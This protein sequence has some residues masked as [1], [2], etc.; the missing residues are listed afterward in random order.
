MKY[1][2]KHTTHYQYNNQVSMCFNEARMSPL[3][4]AHQTCAR[5][6]FVIH[7]A[8]DSLNK[9]FDYFGNQVTSFDILQPHREMSVT[10]YSE[11]QVLDHSQQA[12]FVGNEP[13]E[14]VRDTLA[15]TTNPDYLMA[16]EYMM[17]SMLIPV[18]DEV[19]E[20]ALASFTPQRP[21]MDAVRDLMERIFTD[22][23]YDPGFSTIS[24]PLKTVLAHRRGVC[25]DFAHL[26]IACVRS[27][28]L[29]AGYVS[30]Y[31]ETL[32]PPGEKKME[33]ADASHAWFS[34]YM[35][36]HGWVQF[37]PTNNIL[38]SVQHITLAF[39]R[40]FAD[41]TPLKGVIYGGDDHELSV[42]VDVHRIEE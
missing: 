14:S 10:V 40:D 23:K 25:Q 13:W 42:F 11:V 33:G 27:M 29:A 3:N 2:I 16:R 12:L 37:D 7:P 18:F 38:P 1:R 41:V 36:E 34:V 9:R 31:L 5:N 8:P 22:F 26:G 24:T 17:P 28:G 4:G 35:L 21:V 30:G 6:R 19:R 20:Y 39:G 32:P 15:R